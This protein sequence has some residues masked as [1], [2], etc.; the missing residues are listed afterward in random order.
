MS[1]FRHKLTEREALLVEL[2]HHLAYGSPERMGHDLKLVLKFLHTPIRS[3][4]GRNALECLDAEGHKFVTDLQK[5][6]QS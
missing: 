5:F 3:K 2:V 6:L 4:D 1:N